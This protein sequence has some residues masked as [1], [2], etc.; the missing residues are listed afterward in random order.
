[1]TKFSS[2]AQRLALA[3]CLL[4]FSN[5]G[6]G[7]MPDKPIQVDILT[8]TPIHL[9]FVGHEDQLAFQF[10]NENDQPVTFDFSA[11]L[12][13]YDGATLNVEKH[14]TV[15]GNSTS[16]FA[17][18]VKPS[19]RGLWYVDYKIETDKGAKQSD[20]L[21][22]A[23]LQPAGP[24]TGPPNDMLF[25][26]NGG[27]SATTNLTER[28]QD[29][30]IA[31]LCGIDSAR[32][33]VQFGEVEPKPGVW[34]EEVLKRYDDALTYAKQNGLSAEFL[35][36][37]NAQWDAPADVQHS[38]N[39]VDWLFSPPKPEE[40][41]KYVHVVASRYGDRIK[42][43]E[44]WNEADIV[45][46]WT[47]DEDQYLQ[48]LKTSHDEIK[49][50]D[51]SL[52]VM[53]SG[54]ATLLPHG[55]RKHLHFMETVTQKGMSDYEVLAFHQ[56][57][58]F[59]DFKYVL[60][61]PLQRIR[62]ALNPPKPLYFTE[63]AASRYEG[64]TIPVNLLWEKLTYAWSKGA[65]AYTWYTL[66]AGTVDYTNKKAH[67]WGL[68]TD[69]FY[70]TPTYVS[71]NTLITYL[72][73]KRYD[74]ALDMGPASYG[75]R[76]VSP[77]A[78]AI[79]TWA[80]KDAAE[81]RSTVINVQGATKAFVVDPMGNSK[82]LEIENGYVLL[83]TESTPSLLILEGNH[84]NPQAA[85]QIATADVPAY[86]LPGTQVP[87]KV[88]LWNSSGTTQAFTLRPNFPNSPADPINVS[89]P[90]G[91]TNETIVEI[92]PPVTAGHA[93]QRVFSGTIGYE[94]PGTIWHDEMK[95]NLKMGVNIPIAPITSRLPDFVIDKYENVVN[96]NEN[97]PQRQKF[98][99][100]GP[101][102]LSANVWLH[103]T[104]D[105]IELHAVVRDD[106]AS[107]PFTGERLWDGDSVQFAFAVPGQP[108]FWEFTSALS[109]DK[110]EIYCTEHPAGA[111]DT[112]SLVTAQA[113]RNATSYIYDFTIPRAAIGCANGWLKPI[114]FDFLANDCDDNQHREGYIE[115]T[116]GLGRNTN[117]GLFIPIVFDDASVEQP[118]AK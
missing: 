100:K 7:Q 28:N 48:I 101:D 106:I 70:P 4:S 47:G 78:A 96:F 90:A 8:S 76:F 71:Y 60:D 2:L 66:R 9:L 43:W 59:E 79:M 31:S 74:G 58:S 68:F 57:G 25:C 10:K 44:V 19:E 98:T 23:Y 88:T 1:M 16:D 13:S 11:V 62:D 36:C 87:L 108:G 104:P 85:G 91:K 89:V 117:P 32:T 27:I 103:Q 34:N 114:A 26:I 112:T 99:W 83:R 22:F 63:T 94:A 80:T 6:F 53:S 52:Q 18:P 113:T 3:G 82:D 97:V 93:F 45:Q 17:S 46:F 30:L 12:T 50:I 54:F 35:L 15:N 37:Y 84:L 56:H 109:H 38:P 51:P 77:T 69:T 105:A 24:R 118:A 92:N 95:V 75:Y 67:Q 86:S 110:P 33:C 49:S 5:S 116:P 72:R 14:L 73:D 41:R 65:I 107:Q 64:D 61:G 29:V 115:L 81:T 42:Y 55:G 39:R 102:D 20:R 111:T 40:W 21:T